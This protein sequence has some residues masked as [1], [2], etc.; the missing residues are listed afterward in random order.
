MTNSS[1]L[2]KQLQ[3]N[4]ELRNRIKQLQLQ[5]VPHQMS[6]GQTSENVAFTEEELRTRKKIFDETVSNLEKQFFT[7]HR[8]NACIEEENVTLII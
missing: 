1:Q 7:P 5:S 6:P 8:I 2:I 4:D 3:E